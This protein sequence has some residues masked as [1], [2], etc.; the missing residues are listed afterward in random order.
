MKIKF[1]ITD[2]H[3]VDTIDLREVEF[4]EDKLYD[5]LSNVLDEDKENITME[6]MPAPL[7][8]VVMFS[9]LGKVKGKYDADDI[10]FLVFDSLPCFGKAAF[11]FL[12]FNENEQ[13]SL[14][15]VSNELAEAIS[16]YVKNNRESISDEVKE[17]INEKI[18]SGEFD[19]LIEKLTKEK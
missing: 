16:E 1:L 15:G 10:N 13:A 7:H 11:A 12:D 4:D 5:E 19:E 8:S 18:D 6:L 3:E 14:S 2:P 17:K 9:Y